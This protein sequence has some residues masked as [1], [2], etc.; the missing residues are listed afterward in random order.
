MENNFRLL[1]NFF[2][3]VLTNFKLAP[4]KTRAILLD[5]VVYP[6]DS[7]VIY[8]DRL[9]KEINQPFD[10]VE[11]QVRELVNELNGNKIFNVLYLGSD[12]YFRVFIP[13]NKKHTTHTHQHIWERK[14]YEKEID[15]LK[16]TI[17]GES[18][19]IDFDPEIEG[20]DVV[21]IVYWHL[22]E[23]QDDFNV[24]ISMCNAIHLYHTNRQELL[25][26]LMYQIL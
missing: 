22:D 13:K 15:A 10:L 2:I 23:V 18:V 3:A 16:L 7:V 6:E 12:P 25:K 24:A 17:D 1:N 21:P 5:V 20:V 9:A 8:V 11:K 4:E 19:S 14:I 26:K